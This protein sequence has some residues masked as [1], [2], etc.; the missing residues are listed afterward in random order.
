WC[1]SLAQMLRGQSGLINMDRYM[2]AEDLEV[3]SK[4]TNK[5]LAILQ[6]NSLDIAELKQN[7]QLDIFSL[8]QINKTFVNFSNAMGAAER[9]KNTVFPV[10]YRLYL[11]F[12][13]YIFVITLSIAVA[14]LEGYIVIPLLVLISC[15]FFLLEKAA[16]LL[17]DPFSNRPT[18][19][20]ITAIATTIEINIKQLLNEKDVPQPAQ[21]LD[22]YIL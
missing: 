10:T 22:F 8:V 7:N 16:S 17:Q 1:F 19:T 3:I 6:L 13:I 21:P 18:D 2:T 9:I 5:P 15:S 20:P 12:F 11:R 4:Q 14:D